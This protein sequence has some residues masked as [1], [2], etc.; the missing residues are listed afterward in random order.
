M[1]RGAGG[2]FYVDAS[3]F[4]AMLGRSSVASAEFKKA[5]RKSLRKVGNEA[6]QAARDDVMKPPESS[7]NGPHTGLRAG[8]ARGIRTTV[9]AGGAN[10]GVVIRSRGHLAVKYNDPRGWRHPVFGNRNNWVTQV[11]RPDYFEGPIRRNEP[12][13]RAEIQLILG[14]A[15]SRFDGK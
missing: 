8:I 10:A 6:A 12:R 4:T 1:P 5:L 11:G 14:E 7:G 2:S 15:W 13:Y 3:E 9:L